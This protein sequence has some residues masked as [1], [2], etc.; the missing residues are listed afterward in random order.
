MASEQVAE[1]SSSLYSG[2]SP[3]IQYIQLL[4]CGTHPLIHT[5]HTHHI[6]VMLHVL[7]SCVCSSAPHPQNTHM[8]STTHTY[9]HT[10]THT[11]MTL[12]QT[13][14]LTLTRSRTEWSSS[15]P[16]H[17]SWSAEHLDQNLIFS[18]KKI[19]HKTCVTRNNYCRITFCS[20]FRPPKLT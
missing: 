16:L 3:Q 5:T 10:H 11:D 18:K 17:S 7:A 19:G 15:N 12:Q 6:H 2:P 14:P 4:T 20:S 8:H 1:S 13:Y 9:T